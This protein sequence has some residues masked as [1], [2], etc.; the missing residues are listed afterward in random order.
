MNEISAHG[1]FT[2]NFFKNQLLQTNADLENKTNL[3]PN[4]GRNNAASSKSS[5]ILKT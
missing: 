4:T 1:N 3:F 5:L 2:D